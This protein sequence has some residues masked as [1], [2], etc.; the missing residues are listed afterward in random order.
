MSSNLPNLK[1]ILKK[2]PIK[3]IPKEEI[4]IQNLFLVHFETNGSLLDDLRKTY[5]DE[6]DEFRL[7]VAEILFPNHTSKQKYLVFLNENLQVVYVLNEKFSTFD[8]EKCEIKTKKIIDIFKEQIE[9]KTNIK[10][11]NSQEIRG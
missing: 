9:I 10:E 1:N 7:S 3:I 6:L 11:T 4:E 8:K 2:E 5:P